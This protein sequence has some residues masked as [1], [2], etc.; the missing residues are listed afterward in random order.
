[1]TAAWSF[2][3]SPQT[4]SILGVASWLLEIDLWDWKLWTAAILVVLL[5]RFLLP[6]A[7]CML[8]GALTRK[9]SPNRTNPG[10]ENPFPPISAF[11]VGPTPKLSRSERS[12][13]KILDRIVKGQ[14]SA[15]RVA[16][17]KHGSVVKGY[18]K[19]TFPS[20]DLAKAFRIA[21]LE[22]WHNARAIQG[23]V[24]AAAPEDGEPLHLGE[25]LLRL[26]HQ[27]ALAQIYRQGESVQ[28]EFIYFSRW[29]P[30]RPTFVIKWRARSSN[31]TNGLVFEFH[32]GM[33]KMEPPEASQ[34]VLKELDTALIDGSGPSGSIAPNTLT[35]LRTTLKKL[36]W[37]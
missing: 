36:F 14:P 2:F 28:G 5:V 30:W 17:C 25:W 3:E 34:Q 9:R 13:E 32:E 8:R 19:Q 16:L 37:I 21:A 7:A 22:L 20:I 10:P 33:I 11:D 27:A 15:L 26:A 29:R 12:D 6:R 4:V 18:L 23:Y 24:N 31:W 1:M 35:L